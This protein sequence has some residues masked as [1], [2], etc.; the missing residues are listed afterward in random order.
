MNKISQSISWFIKLRHSKLRFVLW[1]VLLYE[2]SK[3]LPMAFLML[4]I[5]LNQNLV[6]SI[7]DGF[8]V[9]MIGTEVLSFIKLRGESQIVVLFM[10]LYAKLCNIMITEQVF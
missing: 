9:I 3:L 5:L 2:L 1:L 7:K 8:V 10:I 4:F 6:R